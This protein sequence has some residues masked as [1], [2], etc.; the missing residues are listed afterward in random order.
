MSSSSHP[1]S[2]GSSI[3]RKR[4]REGA[5]LP[6]AERVAAFLTQARVRDPAT[7]ARELVRFLALASEAAP[8]S[9]SPSPLVDE[10]WH[11]LILSTEVYPQVCGAIGRGGL[12]G[13]DPRREFDDEREKRQRYERSLAAYASRFMESAPAEV[14]PPGYLAPMAPAAEA[15]AS[16]AY[17]KRS[18]HGSMRIYFRTLTGNI[19]TLSVEPSDS[20]ASVKQKIHAKEGIPPE[21]QRIVY[22]GHPLEDGRTL[23]DYNIQKESMLYLVLNLRGN[24]HI[25]VRTLTGR[26][27]TLIVEPS[28]SIAIVKQLIEDKEGIPF[29]QQRIIFTGQQLEDGR[30]LS[31][32]NIQK[33]STLELVIRLRGCMQIYVKTLTG[34]T[35]TL[36][37]DPSD[38]IASVKQQIQNMDGT[39]IDQQ[40]AH[41]GNQQL[42]DGRALSDYNIQTGS[43]LT[44]VLRLR[45]C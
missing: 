33:G 13:H 5:A 35:V 17:A 37:V 36:D 15:P 11:M 20:I 7:K 18:L 2:S 45:G 9:L 8:F 40:G 31:D 14:W 16:S 26:R 39:P 41:F 38:S 42:E 10:A 32:Y 6:V 22:A 30:T 27:I 44:L 19:I 3:L 4:G 24:L 43:T 23:S 25:Y 28:D 12:I 29:D 21:Q 1:S 34:K